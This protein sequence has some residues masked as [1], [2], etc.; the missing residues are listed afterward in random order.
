MS[1][2]EDLS[3]G[4]VMFL[5]IV[6]CSPARITR[7]HKLSL[8][9]E[10]ILDLGP[11]LSHFAFD[12]GGFS[13]EMRAAES[14]LSEDGAV[15]K[16]NEEYK[17]TTYG[18]D[19]LAEASKDPKY[20]VLVVDVPRVVAF[21]DSLSDR[22]LK[23]LSYI[24]YRD[25]AERSTIKHN[26]DLDEKEYRFGDLEVVT[27]L[28]REEMKDRLIHYDCSLKAIDQLINYRSVVVSDGGSSASL[29]TLCDGYYIEVKKIT[30]MP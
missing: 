14:S 16:D 12:Y 7:I 9:A 18:S 26:M 20:K 25:T 21:L 23:Q 28:T 30:R 3:A 15:R 11:E 8:F 4:D 10:R 5:S 2:V 22:D 6:N 1:D 19:L 24:L 27:R 17:L 29:I 13:N